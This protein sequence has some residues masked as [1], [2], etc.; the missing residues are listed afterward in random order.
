MGNPVLCSSEADIQ[1]REI[2]EL[3]IAGASEVRL[4]ADPPESR[5]ARRR[6][7]RTARGAG[8][9]AALRRRRRLL[10]LTLSQLLL[11]FDPVVKVGAMAS[12][13]RSG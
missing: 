5:S 12:A 13:A 8:A 10:L 6:T 7:L 4:K 2:E 11:G 3:R 9:F 1:I